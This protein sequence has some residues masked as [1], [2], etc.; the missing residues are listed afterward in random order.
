MNPCLLV[1]SSKELF[2]ISDFY[3]GLEHSLVLTDTS[4]VYVFGA[5]I[6]GQL[7]L[8]YRSEEPVSVPHQLLCLSGLPIRC[9]A[10]GGHHSV[11][12]TMS[13]SLFTWGANKHGQL[14][15][16]PVETVGP[17]TN[18]H[19]G[20]RSSIEG[21]QKHLL[22]VRLLCLTS[23]GFLL[24]DAPL[25]F[26]QPN[27]T[28]QVVRPFRGDVIAFKPPSNQKY[29]LIRPVCRN[30]FTHMDETA[31]HRSA[32]QT[33]PCVWPLHTQATSCSYEQATANKARCGK[34]PSDIRKTCPNQRSPLSWIRCASEF[35]VDAFPNTRRLTFKLLTRS[36]HPTWARL[37]KYRL[38]KTTRRRMFSTAN[39]RSHSRK[40]ELIV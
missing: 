33:V 7:G 18:E 24:E 35:L 36:L 20:G 40:A 31:I 13:G 27:M 21:A 32:Y 11:V 15:L 4:Q 34:R 29:N 14:G 5:N 30:C 38:S 19:Y 25:A 37:R 9:I 23:T 6:W 3:L 16:G 26:T 12:L 22:W 8:G 28:Y 17:T 2:I 10:A 1:S 39:S